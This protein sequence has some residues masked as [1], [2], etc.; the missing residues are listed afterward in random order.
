MQ[1]Y[2]R[3]IKPPPEELCREGLCQMGNYSGKITDPDLRKT[4]APLG[5]PLP[6]FLNNLRLKEWQAFQLSNREW[7][8]CLAVYNAKL[9][10][11]VVIMAYNK[12]ENRVYRYE[13]KVP[14]WQLHLPLGLDK[15]RCYYY[16]KN[17]NIDIFNNLKEDTI[18]MEFSAWNFTGLPAI[19]GSII[20][21]NT[22]D[23][24]VIVHP[25]DENRPLYSHKALMSGEGSLTIGEET[26]DFIPEESSVILDD[27]KGFYP[28][29]MKY[30]WITT[31]GLD[32]EGKR[33]GINLTRN[34]IKNPGEFNENGLWKNG[35]LHPLPPV[36][37]SRPD[38]V[39]GIWQVRDEYGW[40]NLDFHPV[41]DVPILFDLGLARSDY[42]GVFGELRGTVSLPGGE[43][44][45][46]EGF[47][48]MGEQK[49][50][51]L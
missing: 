47:T 26:C 20:A 8:I 17:L 21:R 4:S 31:M 35:Q 19:S 3:T 30:D 51:T 25:F 28:R 46:F 37:F 48:A 42:H 49:K 22:G 23:P 1:D 33:I 9:L 43:K 16:S 18:E 11:I 50:I 10:G 34:Q 5:Y 41:S 36:T 40:I 13:R 7:F 29:T 14:P 38:G 24:L 45:S 44:V 39:M 12:K 6:R 15:S 32:G 2:K 27:H